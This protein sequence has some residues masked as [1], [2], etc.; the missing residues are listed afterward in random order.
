MLLAIGG[1][2]VAHALAAGDALP[3]ASAQEMPAT[4]GTAVPF[5]GN[6]TNAAPPLSPSAPVMI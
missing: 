6:H 3:P 4:V 2:V 5:S 1:F